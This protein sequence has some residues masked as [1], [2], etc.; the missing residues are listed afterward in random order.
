MYECIICY[1][2]PV[3]LQHELFIMQQYIARDLLLTL[4]RLHRAQTAHSWTWGHS[5]I[6]TRRRIGW[7]DLQ[8]ND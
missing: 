8:T 1:Y 7:K 5:F 4:V 3:I 6:G 2:Y